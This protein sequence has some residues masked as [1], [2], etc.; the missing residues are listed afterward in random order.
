MRVLGAVVST[1]KVRASGVGSTLPAVSVARTWNVCW[2]SLSAAVVNGDEHDAK[3]PAS[4]AHWNVDGSLA[5]NWKVG[6]VLRVAVGGAA[7]MVVSGASG[8]G[9]TTWTVNVRVAGVG[10]TLRAASMAR[11]WKVWLPSAS[12]WVTYGEEHG[13]KAPSSTRHSY[14]TPAPPENSKAGVGSSVV[15]V[16]P[17]VIVVSGAIVS[18][19][20]VRAA[21]VGSTLPAASS[22]RTSSVCRPSARA[23][24]TCGDEQ[25]ANV[26]PSRRHWKLAPVSLPWNVNAG[27]ASPVGAGRARG[28]RRVRRARVHHDGARRRRGVGVAGR[29]D[30]AHLERVRSVGQRGRGER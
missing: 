21:G 15:P 25:A 9:G 29:V 20:N 23:E 11:T 17:E 19:V 16:G 2:P 4:T 3:L 14:V 30:R 6:V 8:S 10:S 22:A 7:V 24:A 1:V 12:V 27:E 28:D 18:T 5:L 13:A 26:P